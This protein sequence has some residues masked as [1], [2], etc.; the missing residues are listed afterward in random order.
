MEL[1]LGEECYHYHSKIVYKPP[2]DDTCVDWHQGYIYWY[3]EGCLYPKLV[4]CTMA[5]TE[6]TKA[7]GCVQFAKGSH[8]MGPIDPVQGGNVDICEP[9]R[10]EKVLERLEVVDCEMA[11]GDA[12]FCHGNAI[13]GSQG[14]QTGDTRILIHSHYNAVSNQLVE[15]EGQKYHPYIPIEKLPDSAIKNGLY[16]SGFEDQTGNCNSYTSDFGA[17]SQ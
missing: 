2:Y 13:H 15:E 14:N 10:I 1:I 5:I 16:K 7:N 8:L 17:N 12:L 11:P 3:A 6:S 4:S 9:K